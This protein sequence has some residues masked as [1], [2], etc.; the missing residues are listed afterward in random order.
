M[1]D[2]RL[3][4]FSSYLLTVKF[5]SGRLGAWHP[6]RAVKGLGGRVVDIVEVVSSYLL[7]KLG[8]GLVCCTIVQQ[9]FGIPPEML[10]AALFR[11]SGLLSQAGIVGSSLQMVVLSY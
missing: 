4:L 8:G 9:F 11:F 3:H 1:F 7:S 2:G 10:V 6:V 5:L